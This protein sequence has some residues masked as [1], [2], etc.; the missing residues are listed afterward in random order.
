MV[1]EIS[2]EI[3]LEDDLKRIAMRIRA[4]RDEAGLTLQQ[5][6]DQSGVSASTI[7]KIEN[8]QTVPTIAVLLKVANGLN[9]RPSELLADVESGKQVAVLPASERQ[10]LE[11]PG[12]AKM[13]HLAAMIPRNRLDVWR[14]TLQTGHGPGANSEAWQF[15]GEIVLLIE[16]G[17]IELEIDGESYKAGPGDSVHFETTS[18]HRWR[19]IGGDPVRAIVFALLPERM[20]GDLLT[21]ISM[22]SD[23]AQRVLSTSRIPTS[24]SESKSASAPLPDSARATVN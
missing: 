3:E 5:L 11:V 8:L 4:W 13:E 19:A 12:R 15:N 23:V 9:R 14:V 22:S 10:H 7:H 21:R 16:S 17:E 2:G 6:G 20:Q 1:A 18:P 24:E